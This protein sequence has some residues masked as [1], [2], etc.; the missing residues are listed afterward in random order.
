[1]CAVVADF[2]ITSG[3]EELRGIYTEDGK[4]NEKRT[5]SNVATGAVCHYTNERW[6]LRSGPDGA[7]QYEYSSATNTSR[8]V[9]WD[10]DDEMN[11][12]DWKPKQ[13]KWSLRGDTQLPLVFNGANAHVLA[14]S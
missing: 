10:G 7:V 2:T 14:K 1:M 8:D 6:S 3:P 13:A 9:P 11:G 12:G 4:E 5:F